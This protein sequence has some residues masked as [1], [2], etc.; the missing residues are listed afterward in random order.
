[1]DELV[2]ITH[3]YIGKTRIDARNMVLV[4]FFMILVSKETSCPLLETNY[5]KAAGKRCGS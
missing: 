2:I 4:S 1:M 5:G 3:N